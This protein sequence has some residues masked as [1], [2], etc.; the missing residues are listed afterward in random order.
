[1]L[2][3]LRGR[4]AVHL[5][6]LLNP[7]GRALGIPES[8]VGIPQPQLELGFHSGREANPT[9]KVEKLLQCIRHV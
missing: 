3:T 9:N 1:M 5:R 2:G 7:S 4:A 6:Q 8:A